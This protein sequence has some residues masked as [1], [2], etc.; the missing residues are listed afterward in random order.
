MPTKSQ[1][2]G[3]LPSGDSLYLGV[4][5]SVDSQK[6]GT[7][8]FSMEFDS[9]HIKFDEM[10]RFAS[11]LPGKMPLGAVNTVFGR[12]RRTRGDYFNEFV[13]LLTC[14]VTEVSDEQMRLLPSFV[15]RLNHL[16]E[17]SVA[18]VPVLAPAM[19]AALEKQISLEA[20]Q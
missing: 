7:L 11:G 6:F 1:D 4:A 10:D 17:M 2:F 15:Q 16:D 3:F 14:D 13:H 8:I 18:L 9:T 12:V 19:I 5:R 20:R